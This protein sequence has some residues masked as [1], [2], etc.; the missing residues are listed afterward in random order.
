MKNVIIKIII[1]SVFI[2]LFNLIFFM[3]GIEL[4]DA[5]WCTYAFVMLSYLCLLCT[6]FLTRNTQSGVLAGSLWLR[7]GSY[8]ITE[9]IVAAICLAAS[10]DRITWPL[11]SQSV[12][13]AIFLVLQLMSV[14]A[15]DSTEES[16]EQ[17][18]NLSLSKQS[19]V[20]QLRLSL[21]STDNPQVK[22][23]LNRC[24][25]A[26]SYSPLNTHTATHEATLK[27]NE[28]VNDICTMTEQ[29][30]DINQ[31]KQKERQLLMTIQNRNLQNK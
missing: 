7:A 28:T 27:I 26:V 16:L 11:I 24:I 20:A 31:L 12:I 21:H 3:S 18:K 23:I 15:N 14:L 30:T 9:L 29:E 8:F 10:P 13:F 22:Q 5:N 6:S 25:D 1:G 19:L 2:A 17:Q 4:S